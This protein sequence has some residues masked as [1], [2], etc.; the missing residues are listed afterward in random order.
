MTIEESILTPGNRF[1][2]ALRQLAQ[3][4]L[5]LAAVTASLAASAQGAATPGPK[6][7]YPTTARVEY[8]Q[9][10]VNG[11]GGD[12][13]T[14]YKCSCAIDR[15]ADEFDYDRYV[16]ASTFARYATLGGEGGG[17]FRDTDDARQTA[18]GYRAL[19]EK[20]YAQCGLKR[21]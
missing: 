11:Q 7:S 4:L 14:L 2:T 21:R 15:I 5:A 9:E 19:E 8:V 17:I 16:E 1:G 10:C 6:F 13:V 3:A 20:A 12:F 18:K